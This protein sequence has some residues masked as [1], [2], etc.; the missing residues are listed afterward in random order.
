MAITTE[1]IS[2]INQICAERGIDKEEVIVSLEQGILKAY[3]Y[4]INREEADNVKVEM[5]R[6]TGEIKVL[7]QKE[8]VKRVTDDTVQISDKN[9][10]LF[11]KKVKVG[12]KIEIEIPFEQFGRIAAQV[13]K[14]V[15]I[16]GVREKEKDAIIR[17]Y[18][19]QVGNIFSALMQRMHKDSAIFEIGKAI[20]FMPRENQVPGE[21]YKSGD[22]YKV[23]LMSIEDNDQG[24]HLIVD[25][26]SSKFLN[27]LFA[28]EVPE[29]ESGVIEIVE[30]AREAGSRSK[31]AVKS[32]QE[33]IDPIGSCVGQ[34]GVRI[35]SVMDEL[36]LEKIDIIEWSPKIE[37]FV[38]NAL[39]PAKVESVK[40]I[41]EKDE[42]GSKIRVAKVKVNADQ[43][44]LAIGRDGQN[45][46]LA[47]KLV[48]MK[49][50]IE[51]KGELPIKEKET[52]LEESKVSIE[53]GKETEKIEND[54]VEEAV[55]EVSATEEKPAE[56][57]VKN[58][59]VQ[60]EK[61]ADDS[62]LK[63]EKASKNAD[64]KK[65]K[66]DSVKK[67]KTKTKKK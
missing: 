48:G 19:D 34:K 63:A 35:A 51:G 60:A 64:S 32:N 50:D 26:A 49:I 47:Y 56:E 67:T 46:R 55:V 45:V 61:I 39:S 58:V 22:R 42:L 7:V 12:D 27:T 31:V 53:E 18:K 66:K 25:R 33:G 9:A 41:E 52:V 65:E 38:A 40:I 14:Q 5:N 20:A 44:S 10:R 6:E 37:Q 30:C 3:L 13:A 43:L 21:F 16:Q 28:M 1:I 24:K 62:N 17:E 2:A 23:L 36:G 29:I 8:V 59:D 54:K 11:A 15:L 57:A 4:E